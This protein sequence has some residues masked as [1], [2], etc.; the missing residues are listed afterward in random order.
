MMQRGRWIGHI[1]KESSG[2]LEWLN[3]STSV[4]VQSDER[5]VTQL[6]L[7]RTGAPRGKFAHCTVAGAYL[8]YARVA[9][10]TLVVSQA[11]HCRIDNLLATGDLIQA[12]EI[13]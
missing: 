2:Q 5:A 6:I 9:V 12:G 3:Q 10:S 4:Q 13:Q 8:F 11:F 1:Y 7:D